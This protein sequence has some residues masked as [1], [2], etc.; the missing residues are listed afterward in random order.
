MTNILAVFLILALGYCLGSLKFRGLKLGSSGVLLVALIFGHFGIVLPSI[1]QEL[2]LTIFVTSVGFIAG[3]TF[4]RNFKGKA[5]AYIVLG[6]IIIL[7]GAAVC[8]LCIFTFKIPTPLAV[9]LMTGALTSTPG[10]AAAMEATKDAAASIGYG[11]AYP[12]GVVGVVLFVQLV[13]K[14]FKNKN[15][16]TVEET[17]I[18]DDKI[19]KSPLFDVEPYGF[20]PLA[21]AAVLGILLAKVTIP[22]PYGAQFS[23][24]ISGGPLA[25]GLIISHFGHIG[26]ISLEV[27]KGTLDVAREFGLA[28]FLMGAGTK[29]GIGF[30]ET[31]QQYGIILFLWGIVMTVLPMII[32]YIIAIKLFH[33]SALNALSSICGGMTSTPALG[34]LIQ[35]SDT[36][37]DVTTGYAATYPVALIFVVLSA[38][39]I[40]IIGM[41]IISKLSSA[42]AIINLAC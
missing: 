4:F 37:D 36:D 17:C 22:L 19:N 31:L 27:P 2:G 18:I 35:I 11:I 5:V 6:I 23:L 40:S 24:G 12:F 28:L 26:S 7:T 32:G 15:Y 34:A 14:I 29:A 39:F 21:I 13:P 3:P 42:C 41:P 10:L 1:I 33:L 9:G 16:K 30:I 38:Q 25:I 20:F 8:V